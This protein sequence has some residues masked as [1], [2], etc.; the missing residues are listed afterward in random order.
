MKGVRA[1]F[2]PH[3]VWILLDKAVEEL[4]RFSSVKQLVRFLKD[5]VGDKSS[6]KIYKL[7]KHILRS[8][9]LSRKS[10]PKNLWFPEAELIEE[11]LEVVRECRS[12]CTIPGT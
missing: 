1:K 10:P 2:C 8:E 11:G 12:V 7:L 4:T 5:K 6:R 9:V 3:G